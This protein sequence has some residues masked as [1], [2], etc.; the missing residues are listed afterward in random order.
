MESAVQQH[1]V[2]P[3]LDELQELGL[4]VVATPASMAV[5]GNEAGKIYAELFWK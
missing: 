4:N 3:Y 5:Q 2:E 1:A